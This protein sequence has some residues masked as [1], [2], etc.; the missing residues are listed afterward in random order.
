MLALRHRFEATDKRQRIEADRRRKREFTRNR[1]QREKREEMED[2]A[3]DAVSAFSSAVAVSTPAPPERVAEFETTLTTYEVAVVASLLDNE[4]RL[5]AVQ[6][7]IDAMLAEAFV[8]ED[9]RRVF[10]TEDGEHVFDEHGEDVT[11]EIDPD[12]IPDEAPTWESYSEAKELEQ[13]LEAEREDILAY[14]AKLNVARAEIADGEITAEDLDALEADLADSM[15]PAVAA[16]VD[17]LETPAAEQANDLANGTTQPVTQ[18]VT[19]T[20]GLEMNTPG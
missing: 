20:A 6:G 13:G 12:S 5:A 1:E 2:R 4:K 17:G 8:L 19:K 9:G 18:V 16:H 3:E 10:K 11:D 15:P 14:Q 7:I